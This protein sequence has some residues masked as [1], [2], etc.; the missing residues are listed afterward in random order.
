MS[1]SFLSWR[2]LLAALG[3]LAGLATLGARQP[4]LPPNPE[5]P[6]KT[7]V[8]AIKT[9]H[10]TIKVELFPGKAPLSVKNFLGYVRKKHYDGLVFHRVIANFMIQGGGYRKGLANAATDA[11]M[12]ALEAPT[13]KPIKNEAGNGLSNKRGTLAMARTANPDSATAQFYINV[14]DNDFLD[15]AGGG[16][17]VFGKVI[18][19][20][21]VVDKI[22]KVATKKLNTFSDV[23]TA[24]V[25]IESIRRVPR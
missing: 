20:M 18:A 14:K 13:G 8:C 12:R 21:A 25:V 16:Y 6:A 1:H 17:C 23:P 9:N 11:A 15:R 2:C 24:D 4:P 22:E 19:G 5:P 3:A 7:F 10:G